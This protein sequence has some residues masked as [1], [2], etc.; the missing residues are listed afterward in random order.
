MAVPGVPFPQLI[1]IKAA[2]CS[3][4]SVMVAHCDAA[5]GERGF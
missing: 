4:A 5:K 1:S 3:A 2:R